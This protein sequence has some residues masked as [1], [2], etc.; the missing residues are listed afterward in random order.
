MVKL[1]SNVEDMMIF[2]SN[3][4]TDI[5]NKKFQYLRIKF[6]KGVAGIWEFK[7]Q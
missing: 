2:K 5:L 3:P 6:L 4:H 1:G 7:V